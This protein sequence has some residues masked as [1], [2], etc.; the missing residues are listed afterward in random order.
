MKPTNNL[1]YPGLDTIR[2]IAAI[3][4]V[5]THSAFFAGF[6]VTGGFLG[7]ASARLDIGVALF[8]VLSGFLLSSPFLE[9]ASLGRNSPSVGRYLF[10]RALRILPLYWVAVVLAM[11]LL[12][13][14]SA[15]GISQWIKNLTLTQIYFPGLQS[16]GLTQMWSLCTEVAFYLF[17]PFLM[18][19]IGRRSIKRGWS[20]RIMYISLGT[21]VI[22]NLVWSY[23]IA[24]LSSN[25]GLWLPAYLSWFATGI[26]LAVIKIEMTHN[27]NLFPE[28]RQLSLQP[29][30][31][32]T[33]ALGLFALGATPIGGPVLLAPPE[34]FQ[35]IAKNLLYA[36][37]SA[38]IVLPT[39]FGDTNNSRY[40]KVMANKFLRHLGHISYGIFALHMIVLDF[41]TPLLGLELFRGN[42]LQVFFVVLGI[43]LIL[44]EISYHLIEKPF[45]RLKDFSP[46]SKATPMSAPTQADEIH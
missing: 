35:A 28:L 34:G 8:F 9:R 30:T 23:F 29:G 6:Y 26:L 44:A 37:I 1:P 17:L 22:I 7:S 5:G 2:A 40:H 16:Q 21:A 12:P 27:A 42:G 33:W 39:I 18:V 14:N 45:L 19:H 32:W 10:K 38:L 36:A 43:S 11:T 46:G 15:A 24:P 13:N 25:M 41:T 31:A 20:A 4:V 3:S